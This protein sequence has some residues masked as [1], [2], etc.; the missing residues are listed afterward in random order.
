[1]KKET[2]FCLFW[3]ESSGLT[4]LAAER[5]EQAHPYYTYFHRGVSATE[6][7]NIVLEYALERAE[8]YGSESYDYYIFLDEDVL[9]M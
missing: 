9:Y 8:H 1:M 2:C 5:D 7:R 3:N 4:P 6:G